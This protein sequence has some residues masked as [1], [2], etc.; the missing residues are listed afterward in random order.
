MTIDHSHI[1][2]EWL[3]RA[4]QEE[5]LEEFGAEFDASLNEGEPVK[6][7]GSTFNPA[8]VLKQLDYVSYWHTFYD[9][10]DGKRDGLPSEEDY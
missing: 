3:D 2:Q 7:A 8:D 1:T 10:V 9:F 4:S 5:L 6:V